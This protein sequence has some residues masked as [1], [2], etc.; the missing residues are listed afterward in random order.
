[1]IRVEELKRPEDEIRGR[2][3]EQLTD[4]K[5]PKVTELEAGE[6]TRPE[7]TSTNTTKDR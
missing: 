2:Q 4:V 5:A 7:E 3:E 6:Q 1:V